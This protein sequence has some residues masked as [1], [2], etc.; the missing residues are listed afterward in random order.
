MYKGLAF[1]SMHAHGR[2]LNGLLPHAVDDVERYD[3]R[4]GEV[5]AG[6]VLGYNFGDGHFHNEQLLAAVQ[7]RC[8]FAAGEL[9]VV[10]IESQP[11][12]V[13]RQHYRIYDAAEG[14]IEEGYV[15]VADMVERQPWLDGP[16]RSRSRSPAPGTVRRTSTV[17]ARA[18]DDRR[19]GSRM[20]EAI[21]VGSG[22]NGLVCAA[23]LA[24]A[25]VKVTVLEAE[26]TIGGGT[27]SSEL[28]LPG[29]LHDDCSAVHAMAVGAPSL[30][31]LGLE[32]HGLQ[33][34]WPEVD[35][36]HPLDGGSAGVM[37]A[38]ARGHRAG[39][40]ADGRTWERIF[41]SPVARVRRAERGHH[42]ADPAR[43]A[44]P[45]PAGALRPPGGD[46][47]DA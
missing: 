13:Q 8:D 5:V 27:R 32:R 24:R 39:L 36:A 26:Q 12:H 42:A 46:A 35:L 20:S 3:V 14:L 28:T 41:G 4:E 18:G 7:E 6:V 43:A 30:N 1:R 11:A 31:E 34:C 33:W 21:V 17:S 15:K 22:P 37:R 16:A 19:S 10:M 25:G 23:M 44:A 9:R 29:L 40:G 2:A 45:A 47:G 38:L